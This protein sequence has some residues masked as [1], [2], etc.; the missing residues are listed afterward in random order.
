MKIF[1]WPL[2]NS[3]FQHSSEFIRVKLIERNVIITWRDDC[4]SQKFR[5]DILPSSFCVEFSFPLGFWMRVEIKN[6]CRE[7]EKK[8]LNWYQHCGN[9]MIKVSANNRRTVTKRII[10]LWKKT[11]IDFC[12]ELCNLNSSIRHVCGAII[13][14]YVDFSTIRWYIFIKQLLEFLYY[15]MSMYVK[16]QC[17]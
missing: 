1:S 3:C 12:G 13:Y 2:C 4:H 10:N 5:S 16:P 6:I 15:R 7:S 17:L 8:I 14:L 9:T 11:Q